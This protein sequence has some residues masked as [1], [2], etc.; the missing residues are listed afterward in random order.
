MQQF[1]ARSP[2]Q[3][4]CLC[5]NPFQVRSMLQSF[6]ILFPRVLQP[7]RL[8][9]FQVRSMLQSDHDS[10]YGGGWG[11]SIPFKSGQCCNSVD[12]ELL[13]VDSCLSQSLSSQ[14]NAAI[15]PLSAPEYQAF[16]APFA[17]APKT[18]HFFRL[19]NTIIHT[20]TEKSMHLKVDK[21]TSY[22][23]RE[24]SPGFRAS[25]ERSQNARQ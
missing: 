10:F 25:P 22:K 14:V 17:S 11:V 23:F 3:P 6:G 20:P 16:P 13:E 9:P 19:K 4:R 21:S 12:V 18:C 8:N 2:L 1:T 7:T 15:A 24:R 5:L